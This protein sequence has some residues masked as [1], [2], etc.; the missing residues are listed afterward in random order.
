MCLLYRGLKK[1][2]FKTAARRLSGI[3]T[4]SQLNYLMMVID[5]KIFAHTFALF[6]SILNRFKAYLANMPLCGKDG[7]ENTK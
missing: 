1:Q 5:S 6:R 7:L 3:T 2:H 4:N